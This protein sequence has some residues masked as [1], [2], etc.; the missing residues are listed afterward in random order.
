MKIK[1]IMGIILVIDIIVLALCKAA[2]EADKRG[3]NDIE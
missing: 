2:S 3:G 1:I